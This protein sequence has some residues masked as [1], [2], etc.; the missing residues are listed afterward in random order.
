MKVMEVCKDETNSNPSGATELWI[1]ALTYFR[2]LPGNE[3]MIKDALHFIVD[4][5]KNK[6]K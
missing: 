3:I 2:D 6:S 4:F 1:Q 5:E